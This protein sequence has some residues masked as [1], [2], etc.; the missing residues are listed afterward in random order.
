M[1]E[2]GNTRWT[3]GLA[4]VIAN[5]NDTPHSGLPENQSPNDMAQNDILRQRISKRLRAHAL[6]LEDKITYKGEGGDDTLP[7]TRVRIRSNLDMSVFDKASNPWSE[8]VYTVIDGKGLGYVIADSQG[9]RQKR[10]YM[11]YELKITEATERRNKVTESQKDGARKSKVAR[12]TTKNLNELK[13]S[14]GFVTDKP[15][16]TKRIRKKPAPKDL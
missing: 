8:E 7:D 12:T 3:S 10:K 14:E 6:V 13:A 4:D 1:L 16:G 9:E 11:P 5:Y 2:Q 15:L